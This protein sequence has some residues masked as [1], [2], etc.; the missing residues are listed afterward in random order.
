[1]ASG[2]DFGSAFARAERAAGR[3]LPVRGRVFVSVR[4][5][6]KVALVGLGRGFVSLGF[7]LLAT[8]GTAAALE[9]AGIAV[10]RVEKGAAVVE[11]LSQGGVDLVVN[12]PQGRNARRDGYAIREAALLA[13]ARAAVAAIASREPREPVSLQERH[14]ATRV[15]EAAHAAA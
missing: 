7:E 13:G 1:M 2:P 12:T 3:A 8:A 5:A 10:T 4:D 9:L 11:L 6:D 15:R 14:A